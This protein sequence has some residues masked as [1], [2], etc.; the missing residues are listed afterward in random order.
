M[1]VAVAVVVPIAGMMALVAKADVASLWWVGA[2]ALAVAV[3]MTIK[4]K[5]SVVAVAA[6]GQ[7]G[8]V[9]GRSTEAAVALA[10]RR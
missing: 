6:W 2:A 8:G 5:A 7:H 9:G 10:Q 3:A 4:T 1:T